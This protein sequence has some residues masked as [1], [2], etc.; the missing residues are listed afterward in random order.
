MHNNGVNAG[1]Y[2]IYNIDVRFSWRFSL[3][4][5]PQEYPTSLVSR[6]PPF[7][8]KIWV[9]LRCPPWSPENRHMFFGSQNGREKVFQPPIFFW[10]QGRKKTWNFGR[11]NCCWFW[12]W[13][14]FN[15][16]QKKA[17]SHVYFPSNQTQILYMSM[18]RKLLC[19]LESSSQ[20]KICLKETVQFWI[21]NEIHPFNQHL[22]RYLAFQP[23]HVPWV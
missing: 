15:E 17:A 11:V 12:F 7:L 13:F 10:D 22:P 9:Q 5:T 19:C 1:I 14:N 21:R 8:F 4:F 3:T 16:T 23:Q 2:I 20:G 6:W 18:P